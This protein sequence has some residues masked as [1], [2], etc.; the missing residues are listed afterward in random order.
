MKG[1]RLSVTQEYG[2]F[3]LQ[4]QDNIEKGK[5]EID[6]LRRALLSTGREAADLFP[7][8]FR[9]A[10]EYSGDINDPEAEYDYSEMGDAGEH[11]SRRHG[12]SGSLPSG[13]GR[14]AH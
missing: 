1:R 7:E 11:V 2:L 5:S 13:P 6:A 4:R 14:G 3:L 10:Q 12:R 8:Y 9:V